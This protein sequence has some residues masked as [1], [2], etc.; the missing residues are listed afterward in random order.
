MDRASLNKNIPAKDNMERN[1]DLSVPSLLVRAA[2]SV[3]DS[4]HAGFCRDWRHHT[5]KHYLLT[6]VTERHQRAV[7][8]PAENRPSLWSV[9]ALSGTSI[10]SGITRRWPC[11]LS[12]LQFPVYFLYQQRMQQW[13]NFVCQR[14]FG[15]LNV[16]LSCLR[17]PDQFL[18]A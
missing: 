9:V 13:R 8:N 12:G 1:G 15:D 7:N 16:M 18:A 6:G 11:G 4:Y 3:D 10:R 5:Y 14:A 2:W 17:M